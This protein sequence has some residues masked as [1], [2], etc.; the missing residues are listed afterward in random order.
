M[1]LVN[2][3]AAETLTTLSARASVNLRW[4]LLPKLELTQ[5]SSLY[6]EGENRSASAV[7]SLD[8]QVI[9][10]LKAR[11]SYDVR[12]ERLIASSHL[13]TLGRAT[14]VISF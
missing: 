13:D 1:R 10:P 2:Q 8:A 5:A 4:T 3:V 12:Y 11:L 6:L 7:T 14:L 9:G